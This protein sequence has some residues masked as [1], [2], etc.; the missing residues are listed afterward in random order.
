MKGKWN[1]TAPILYSLPAM[2][3]SKSCTYKLRFLYIFQVAL[4]VINLVKQ[5]PKTIFQTIQEIHLLAK[6]D[7]QHILEFLHC[8]EEDGIIYLITEYCCNGDLS[9]YT[10]KHRGDVLEEARLVEW[11]RQITLALQVHVSDHFLNR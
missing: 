11:I 3:F 8:S 1:K 9:G 6:L 4:K 10:E 5:D 7:H 2:Y